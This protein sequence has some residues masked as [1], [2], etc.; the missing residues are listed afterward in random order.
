MT[1][2]LKIYYSLTRINFSQLLAYPADFI[3]NTINSLAWSG[4]SVLSIYLL[5]SKSGTLYGWTP[6][7]LILLTAI[8]NAIMGIYR[9]LFDINFYQLSKIINLGQLDGYLLRPIDSQFQ[10]SLWYI[11]YSGVLRL[12]IAFLFILYLLPLNHTALTV[13]NILPF[14]FVIMAGVIIFYSI[15]FF[16]ITFLIWYPRLS[17]IIELINI[18]IGSARYPKEMYSEAAIYLFYIMLPVIL[19]AS[20][21][22]NILIHKNY[23][24]DSIL[25]FIFAVILFIL[26]RFFWKFALRYY[27]SAS[28]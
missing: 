14:L 5:S 12:V 15:N 2:Y 10:M 24:Q 3:I 25:I 6:I 23:L 18:V 8:Y 16:F 7:Q 21:A 22:T 28:G 27:T 11:N 17:N 4:F 1:R 20:T 19:I 13:F 26:S 9:V